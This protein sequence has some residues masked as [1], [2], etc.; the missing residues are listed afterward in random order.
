MGVS[1]VGFPI[2]K[3]RP[4]LT[5]IFHFDFCGAQYTS[6]YLSNPTIL[7]AFV[8]VGSTNLTFIAG[9]RDGHHLGYESRH[10]GSLKL[11]Y[12]AGAR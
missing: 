1:F 3:N 2:K 8:P 10:S 12:Q 4:E 7:A 11:Y 5:G 9:R 6:T